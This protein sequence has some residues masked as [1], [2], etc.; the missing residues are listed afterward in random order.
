MN[1]RFLRTVLGPLLILVT[2]LFWG[3]GFVAQK[4]GSNHLGPLT[5]I[6]LR[7]GVAV[8]F[9]MG[10]QLVRGR[11]VFPRR[12]LWAGLL[13]GVALFLP[14]CAQQYAF[15]YPITPGVCAFLTADYM[16]LVPLF[17][18]FVHRKASLAEWLAL[19]PAVIGTY[20]ICIT[21]AD[22]FHVGTGELFT[23]LC[24]T[25][26]AIE[27]LVVDRLAPG[28]DTLTLSIVMF[29]TCALCAL[30]LLL[31][32]S[33]ASLLSWENIHLAREAILF[34]GLGAS[35]IGF[36]LQ[37]V[38]QGWRTPPAL[39]SIIMSL[40][41]VFGALLGWLFFHDVLSTR[42]LIG[43]AL[44]FTAALLAELGPLLKACDTHEKQARVDS[45]QA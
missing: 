9:L 3:G 34:L 11:L 24:A 26:F 1:K 45:L 2:T 12:T 22:S 6:A 38:A 13:C 5:V 36:T 15:D 31:L 27:I 40:E 23:L 35:G 41:S 25:L 20:L 44:V 37:N 33:E 19:I 16:L 21:G 30:P 42:C 29:A 39:A 43:C 8:L 28:T 10:I 32:P 18:L 7:S 17:G 14:M 4:L